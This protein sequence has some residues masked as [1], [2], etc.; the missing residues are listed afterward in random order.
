MRIEELQNN[1]YIKSAD[2]VEKYLLNII[3]E[4]FRDSNEAL[5]GSKEYIIREAVDRLR[6]EMDYN[7]LGVLSIAL[8]NG[9]VRTG[10]VSITLEDLG[11]E[12]LI[13][14][15]LSAFNV[16]FGNTPNTACEGNDPR[17]SDA[18]KPIQHQH[19]ISEIRGLEGILS[20]ILGQMDRLGSY[21]H[22]HTNKHILDMLTYTGN[23][24][25][26]DLGILDTL[27]PKIDQA[28]TQI[29]QSIEDYINETDTKIEDINN[30]IAEL[31][32]SIDA[33]HQYV[34]EKLDQYLLQAKQYTDHIIDAAKTE[35]SNYIDNNYV[36][37]ADIS[38]LI[39]IAQNC[40]SYV[41]TEV[42]ILKSTYMR[43]SQNTRIANLPFTQNT[44]DKL[45]QRSI[46]LPNSTEVVFKLYMEYQKDGKTIRQSL[47]HMDNFNTR[48]EPF[49][50]PLMQHLTIAGYVEAIQTNQNILQLIF[51]TNENQ[52]TDEMIDGKIVCDIYAKS[53]CPVYY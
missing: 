25:K 47:P 19:E 22:N 10:D 26:I 27:E 53:F 7:S 1:M 33:I 48:F 31:N 44:R 24:D 4:Y 23:K 14:P 18:R 34:I 8:S 38:S 16:N 41:C 42:W 32:R 15:K 43:T 52:L 28:L 51:N 39:D 3:Q 45:A 9:E 49:M 35:M 46:D 50:Y 17:L 29:R 13:S 40:Y 20:T 12:P 11:G 6:T 37:K 2:T 21:N 5:E 30:D 36:K